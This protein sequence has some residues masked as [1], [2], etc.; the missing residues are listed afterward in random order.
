LEEEGAD[1]GWQKA[2]WWQGGELSGASN[3][4]QMALVEV[5]RLLLRASWQIACVKE[6]AEP[7]KPTRAPERA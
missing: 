6:W 3:G 2:E 1:D 7:Q 4:V 5:V